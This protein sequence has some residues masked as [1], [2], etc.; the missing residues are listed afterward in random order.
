MTKEEEWTL[1]K[2]AKQIMLDSDE[3]DKEQGRNFI[4]R[5]WNGF[6]ELMTLLEDDKKGGVSNTLIAHNL[7]SVVTSFLIEMARYNENEENIVSVL[8]FQ[9]LC[10]DVFSQKLEADLKALSEG[11]KIG[12]YTLGL[13]IHGSSVNAA[14][15]L[16][17]KWSNITESTIKRYCLDVRHK[18]FWQSQE[19]LREPFI[20]THINALADV[21]I[22]YGTDIPKLKTAKYG[23]SAK[24]DRAAHKIALDLKQKIISHLKEH[25][26][27]H[28]FGNSQDYDE[29]KE[30]ISR[31]LDEQDTCKIQSRCLQFKVLS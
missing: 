27:S 14:C 2:Q 15:R 18:D 1:E 10:K 17:N 21:L 25:K 20:L 28:N 8:R 31:F 23:N 26:T 11:Q 19:D 16:V 7:I 5:Q 30:H 12:L 4:D 29:R 22:K 13:I 24:Q 6:G 9:A 3:L